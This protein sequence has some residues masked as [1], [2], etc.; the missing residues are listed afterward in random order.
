[1]FR[2]LFSITVLLFV[3]SAHAWSDPRPMIVDDIFRIR[4]NSDPALS[5]DGKWIVFTVATP[6]MEANKMTTDLW[7]I[8]TDGSGLRQLTSDPAQDRKPSWSPDQRWIAFE[9]TRSGNS[10]IWLIGLDGGEARQFTNISTEASQPVWSPDAKKIAFIS[11]VFPEFSVKPFQESDPLN[12][13]KVEQREKSKVKARVITNLLYRHWD[14][15]VDGKRQH[16]FIQSME[17][18]YPMDL[19]PGDRDAIPTSSTFSDG[20]EFA[21]SP[22]GT[23]ISYT[24][25]PKKNEAWD[26]NH[27]I[28]VVPVTGGVPRII[29]QGP[30][31]EGF[32]R[33][34]PN[35]AYIAYRS[36]TVPGYESDRWQLY[37]YDR[38]SGERRSLTANLDLSVEAPV[39]AP[40]NKSLFFSA[41][42]KGNTPIFRVQISGNK[43]IKKVVDQNTNASINVSKDG[44][45][46]IFAR[47]SAV[48]PVEIYKANTDGKKLLQITRMND[49]LF[50]SLAI[51]SPESIS[52]AGEGGTQIQAWFYKP[53]V[54]NPGKKYPFVLLIHGGP[55]SAWANSWSYRWNPALWAAQGYVVLAPNPRGSTGFGSKFQSEI[56]R[57]WGGKVFVDLMKGVDYVETLSY[58]DKGRKAAAGASYGG[59]MV[60]WIEGNASD[61]FKTLVSH[62]GTFNLYSK[63]GTTEELWFNEWE[64]GLPWENAQGYDKFSPHRYAANFKTPMLIIH[65]ELDYRVP[66][67]E[68]IQLFTYL[69]RK[70]VPSK[71][72]YFPDE[73]HWVLKPAN[74][75]FWHQTVFNWLAEYL[76]S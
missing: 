60:N 56:S 54:F 58:V 15:W 19:T 38:N 9:S 61:R 28:Y 48:R 71:W 70:G 18:G 25:P 36:Q 40:D 73:G 23:E 46:L 14:S 39:W 29:A 64:H 5:P 11:A 21:F 2:K 31:A 45:I 65:S 63:Y 51:A 43:E 8:S 27:D 76:K 67:S 34:S 59:Y 52:Y 10:Q 68:G 6:D 3:C 55:Q 53:P 44:K 30:A 7:L 41:E 57:D 12:R 4:R 35:G 66:V 13:Q 62:D 32:P 16:I 37:V 33:Y 47:D 1:M 75:Q 26:T 24:V 69:Q 49:E 20:I 72:L 42:E 22:E 50:A 17:G 74:S